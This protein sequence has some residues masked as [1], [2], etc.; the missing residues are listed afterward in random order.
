MSN[1]ISVPAR[2]MADHR[3]GETRRSLTHHPPS[4]QCWGNSPENENL[5]F[6]WKDLPG[7]NGSIAPVS[8]RSCP[9]LTA[10]ESVLA[11]LCLHTRTYEQQLRRN[12]GLTGPT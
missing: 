10:S 3:M 2:A 5:V 6:P 4:E 12:R 9:I 1:P 7:V 8:S 11:M